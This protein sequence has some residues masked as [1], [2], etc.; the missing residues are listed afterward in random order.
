M[1]SEGFA[2]SFIVTAVFTDSV[3]DFTADDVSV[4]NGTISNFAGS[5][6][7]YNFAIRVNVQPDSL[8]EPGLAGNN[9]LYVRL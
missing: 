2:R 9:S 1:G 4:T 6:K 5:G 3:N 7:T 8:R